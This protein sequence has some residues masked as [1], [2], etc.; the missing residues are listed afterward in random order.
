MLKI[1]VL[2]Y[3]VSEIIIKRPK[4]IIPVIILNSSEMSS[5]ISEIPDS[6]GNSTWLL[7]MLWA[8]VCMFMIMRA[9]MCV[10]VYVCMCASACVYV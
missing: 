5:A 1:F 4:A 9:F 3:L 10:G 2:I 7:C 8:C 6:Y